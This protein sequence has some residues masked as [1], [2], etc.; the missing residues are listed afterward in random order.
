MSNI[1]NIMAKHHEKEHHK[2]ESKTAK[3]HEH[4]GMEKHERGPVKHHKTKTAH[5]AK[6]GKK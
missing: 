3:K 5:K 4:E 1:G 6:V 2:H